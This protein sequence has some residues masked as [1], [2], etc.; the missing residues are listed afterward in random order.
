MTPN[1]DLISKLVFPVITALVVAIITRRIEHRPRLVTY[2]SHTTGFGFPAQGPQPADARGVAAAAPTPLPG[3]GAPAPAAAGNGAAPGAAGAV[4]V[5]AVVIRNMG[6]ETAFNVRVG[7][8]A[9][10]ASY[11]IDP[12]VK[13]DVDF[14]RQD[15]WEILIPA[16]VPSEQITIS[17]LYFPPVFWNAVNTYVKSDEG[18]AKVL[19][20]LPTPRPP[21]WAV[22]VAFAFF[23]IGIAATV[24]WGIAWGQWFYKLSQLPL[25]LR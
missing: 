9:R 18:L 6:K 2:Y 3:G 11:V 5:H 4:H 21:R 24:Y 20:V 15:G 16:L 14:S 23:Y 17:Y 13:H 8:S 1:W 25:L 7:H 10:V 22:A 19:N 12:R